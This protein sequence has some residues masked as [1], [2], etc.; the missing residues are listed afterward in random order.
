M[1]RVTEKDFSIDEVASILKGKEVGAVV[2]FLGVVK[3]FREGE[4]VS[5]MIVEAY[6]EAAEAELEKIRSEALKRFGIIDAAI[7]HRVGRLKPAENIV[8]VA[9]SARNRAEAFE[10]CSWMINKVKARAPI[11][12]KEN[13]A[14]GWRWVRET[15]KP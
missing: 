9:A 10:A 7:I 4:D 3:G 12:K 13:T 2:F 8:L 15:V 1:I 5:E 6:R 11:W 14:R